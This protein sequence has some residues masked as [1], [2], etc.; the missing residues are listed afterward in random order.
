[1]ASLAG[2]A[3]VEMVE[4]DRT[5]G[6]RA[7]VDTL[8][9]ADFPAGIP[10]M[11]VAIPTETTEG[12]HPV[13]GM[14]TVADDHTHALVAALE[15]EALLAPE[16]RGDP[17]VRE[18]SRMGVT[19]AGVGLEVAA[20]TDLMS[21]LVGSSQS[22]SSRPGGSSALIGIRKGSA[23]APEES[24]IRSR[25]LNQSPSSGSCCRLKKR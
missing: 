23:T 7:V 19:M 15:A 9:E 20:V 17:M 22:K 1:M 18:M 14:D 5:A 4:V 25:L 8:E 21:S 2:V 24:R 10:V 16:I 3:S 11:A 6:H 12:G 13:M